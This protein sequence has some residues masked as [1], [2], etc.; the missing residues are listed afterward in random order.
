MRVLLVNM[1]FASVVRPALGISLLKATLREAGHACDVIYP[2]IAFARLLGIANYEQ[3]AVGLPHPL[4]VGE[5]VFTDELYTG[6]TRPAAGYIDGLQERRAISADD[7]ELVLA[8]REH[9]SWFIDRCLRD[10]EWG[11]YALVGFASASAQNVA[12]LALAAQVKARHP[13][14]QIVFGGS[15]WEEEMGREL[16]RRFT[17]VDF[18]CSGEADESLPALV[19]CLERNRRDGLPQIPGI[20]FRQDGES[21]STGPGRPVRGLDEL[22]YPDYTDYF[23]TLA[24][25][26]LTRMAEPAVLME[27]CRGCWWALRHPCSFCGSPGRRRPYREKSVPRILEEIR[28]LV[29]TYPCASME[30]VDDVPSPAFFEEALP[31]LASDPLD[32][33][34][35][36]EVRPEVTETQIALLSNLDASVQ[37]GI[38]SFNDRLLRLMRKGSRGLENIRLLRWCRDHGVPAEWNLVYRVPGE[39]GEDYDQMLALLPSLWSLDPPAGCGPVRLDRFSVYAERPEDHGLGGLDALAVYKYLYP[40]PD[41][42]LR[43]IAYAFEWPADASPSPAPE[44]RLRDGIEA[45]RKAHEKGGDSRPAR[46]LT[47]LE[48]LIL[49][50]AWSICDRGD[51]VTRAQESFP[52]EPCLEADLDSAL[53]TLL[54]EAALVRDGDRYLTIARLPHADREL[55]RADG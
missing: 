7:A 1:P 54:A 23:E 49:E 38:E 11:D 10:V 12:A 28:A 20:V 48:R 39:A 47:P 5:W 15:N 6:R 44:K 55:G 50:A 3:I 26:R 35:F 19:D 16:H 22:P 8:A 13:L 24:A 33:P 43:R 45:W 17:F 40:F 32:V 27:T 29:A 37:P 46:P 9:A 4:L 34:L 2:N 31:E 18:A 41:S 25:N 42:S 14:V 53:A 51:L 21:V 30:I 36:C 52:A